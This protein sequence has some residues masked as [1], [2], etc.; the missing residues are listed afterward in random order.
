MGLNRIISE[1]AETQIAHASCYALVVIRALG[2]RPLISPM[3]EASSP[4]TKR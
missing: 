1:V 3:P 2:R 4:T